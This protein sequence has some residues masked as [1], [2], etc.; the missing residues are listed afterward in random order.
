MN[1]K[2]IDKKKWSKSKFAKKYGDSKWIRETDNELK[3]FW[4]KKSELKV[5]SQT[6]GDSKWIRD[7]ESEFEVNPRGRW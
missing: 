5:N 6:N 7:I 4:H 1:W 3:V 2:W